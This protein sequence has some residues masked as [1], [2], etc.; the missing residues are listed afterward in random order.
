MFHEYF[1]PLTHTIEK[2]NL[3]LKIYTLLPVVWAYAS[4]VNRTHVNSLEGCYATTTPLMLRRFTI[5]EMNSRA[6]KHGFFLKHLISVTSRKNQNNSLRSGIIFSL[7]RLICSQLSKAVFL[8]LV[9]YFSRSMGIQKRQE[10]TISWIFCPSNA[11][12]SNVQS[13]PENKYSF[14]GCL[15]LCIVRESNQC[16]QLGRLLAMLPIHQRC[17]EGLRS[18]K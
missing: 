17:W 12:N 15:R 1:V 8:F 13:F 9:C 2:F 18:K 4:Y 3:S 14:T 16:Q 11:H 10:F 6:F 5:E 7:T